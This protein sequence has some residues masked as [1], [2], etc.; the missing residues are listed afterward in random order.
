MFKEIF[1]SPLWIAFGMC[2][3][4]TKECQYYLTVFCLCR[5]MVKTLYVY[6]KYISV[7]LSQLD[8][9]KPETRGKWLLPISKN[10][11]Q[12]E[13]DSNCGLRILPKMC[14]RLWC[15]RRDSDN[16]VSSPSAGVSV[17]L[18]RWLL[19]RGPR[20]MIIYARGNFC[21][22]G[23]TNWSTVASSAITQD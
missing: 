3:W 2:L 7:K 18:C 13:K 15:N 21:H 4:A 14:C 11:T 8:F 10:R 1:K 6:I 19:T 17:G 5:C 22:G 16:I 23:W 20:S 12:S 9:Y